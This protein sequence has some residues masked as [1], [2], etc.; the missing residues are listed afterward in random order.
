MGKEYNFKIG[1]IGQFRPPLK[2]VGIFAQ[3]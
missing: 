1:E 3:I 2:E